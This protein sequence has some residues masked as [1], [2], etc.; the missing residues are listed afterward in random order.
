MTISF[1]LG[2]YY[3]GL[4][5]A[6]G[7][8]LPYWPVWLADRGLSSFEI[9]LL[10][11]AGI[12]SRAI[13]NPL[14]TGYADRSGRRRSL[15][16]LLQGAATL[17]FLPFILADGFWP[18]LALSLVF[19]GLTGPVMPLTESIT[20]KLARDHDLNYG[21]IRLWG[22][23]AFIVTSVAGGAILDLWAAPSI[24][25]M[26]LITAALTFV[27]GTQLPDV[28][29]PAQPQRRSPVL[30][31]LRQ[32]RF[33][34][35]LLATA[36]LQASHALYYAFGTLHWQRAGLGETLIGV[37]WAE[38]VAAEVLLF[39]WSAAVLKRLGPA[40]LLILAGM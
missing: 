9:S 26:M 2:L 35:F 27:L 16:I 14:V 3:W 32:G 37:Y 40:G 28:K 33:R 34:L 31:V 20:T 11:A 8:F 13:V 21:R 6:M 30:D 39:I 19:Y 25:W 22:S 29:S 23:L 15:I 38:G 1:R 7:I 24:Y 5:M 10:V 17:A 12:G 4:F 36:C 18:L